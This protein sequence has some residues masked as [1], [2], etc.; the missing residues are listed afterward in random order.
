MRLSQWTQQFRYSIHY[1][2]Y[3]KA[4]RKSTNLEEKRDFI[5]LAKNFEL[6]L[7]MITWKHVIFPGSVSSSILHR[8]LLDLIQTWEDDPIIWPHSQGHDP[9]VD[10]WHL[11]HQDMHPVEVPFWFFL[12]NF[13]EKLF[14]FTD[15]HLTLINFTWNQLSESYH[16][17]HHRWV[18]SMALKNCKHCMWN[19]KGFI[20]ALT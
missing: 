12:M 13:Y 16:Q 2:T 9:T 15:F 4:F 6:L 11:L 7:F 20:L 17:M 3:L 1:S 10:V 14:V 19:F 18:A 5:K 8:E